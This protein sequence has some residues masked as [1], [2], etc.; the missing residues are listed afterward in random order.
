MERWTPN[1]TV[2][3]LVHHEGKFL[4]VEEYDKLSATDMPVLNQPAGHVEVDESLIE[5]AVRETLEETGWLVEI[6]AYLGLYINV[7]PNNITYHRHCFIARPL[8]ELPDAE[9]DDGIISAPWLTLDEINAAETA[10]RFRSPM[11]RPC[12][13]DFLAGK[14]Y[15][16]SLIQDFR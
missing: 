12:F 14:S 11:V 6:E 9:L 1:C 10:G 13:D 4:L 3:T 7:A 2:A 8:A 5:A 16:L 15:P